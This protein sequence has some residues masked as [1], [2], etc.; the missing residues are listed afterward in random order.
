MFVRIHGASEA[1]TMLVGICGL[2]NWTLSYT[3]SPYLALILPM[4]F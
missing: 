4:N 2:T 3:L 1:P